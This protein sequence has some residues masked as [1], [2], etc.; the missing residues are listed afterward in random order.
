M[1][2]FYSR[3]VD[4]LDVP[5]VPFLTSLLFELAAN[6]ELAKKYAWLADDACDDPRYQDQVADDF[7]RQVRVYLSNI[8]AAHDFEFSQLLMEQAHEKTPHN[9]APVANTMM[10][11]IDRVFEYFYSGTYPLHRKGKSSNMRWARSKCRNLV[12]LAALESVSGLAG[13]WGG[14]ACGRG[15]FLNCQFLC[16]GDTR[17]ARW[18]E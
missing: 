15:T 6:R 14:S 5:R 1:K 7:R 4:K 10:E 12:R 17:P 9:S 11:N 13:A 8:V 18:A 3:T 16:T 2:E